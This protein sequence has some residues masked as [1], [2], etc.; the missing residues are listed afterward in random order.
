MVI[1]GTDLVHI[2]M[3][4]NTFLNHFASSLTDESVTNSD[5]IME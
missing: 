3:S 1:G 5:F 2:S 4:T